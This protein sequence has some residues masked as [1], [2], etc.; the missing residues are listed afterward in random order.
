MVTARE[1]T[2]T[3]SKSMMKMVEEARDSHPYAVADPIA[4]EYAM[5]KFR[6]TAGPEIK[7]IIANGVTSEAPNVSENLTGQCLNEICARLRF[8]Y[9]DCE[10]V[11]VKEFLGTFA[12]KNSFS[13]VMVQVNKRSKTDGNAALSV[14][15][16]EG[17]GDREGRPILHH[18]RWWDGH[19][20]VFIE[21][22]DDGTV[23]WAMTDFVD[24]DKVD[25]RTLFLPDRFLRFAKDGDGWKMLNGEPGSGREG[26]VDNTREDG[27]PLGV[28][29][30]HFPNGA[31][32]F[33]EYG[34]STVKQVMATQDALNASLMN[35]QLV[36]ALTGM[37]I[38]TATG[39]A[40][41]D[42][43]TVRPGQVWTTPNEN[44]RFADLEPGSIDELLKETEDL[45]ATICS[46]FPVPSYRLGNGDWPA[47]LALQ[48]ADFPM[49]ASAKLTGDVFDPA[50]VLIG[51][52]VVELYNHYTDGDELD[53]SKLISVVWRPADEV[54][55]GTQVEIDQG[56]ADLF[57]TAASLDEVFLRKLSILSDADLKAFLAR[58]KEQEELAAQAAEA[59]GI[60][61][62]QNGPGA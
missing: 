62:D 59:E 56:R 42:E 33:G 50:V 6:P 51:H 16:R 43:M 37:K 31:P 4:R 27:R 57:T 7:A 58:R 25:R 12:T 40:A 26:T 8:D 34:K 22:S 38:Y 30:A 18:E 35:R 10:D 23:E 20:G 32:A 60:E 53:E 54:D 21:K 44:A 36:V 14:S 13:K 29:F 5:G 2:E 19:Y 48:R 52:R 11:A 28:P 49:I 61:D 15:W 17:F 9:Y 47:G 46:E 3:T 55:P 45:R 24:R 41:N 1:L 39:V